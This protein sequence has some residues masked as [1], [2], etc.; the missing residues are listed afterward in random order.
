MA[1]SQIAY[2]GGDVVVTINAI[3][4]TGTH[5]AVTGL[6]AS[7]LSINGTASAVVPTVAN[8]DTGIY[9]LTWT[10][11]T[12]T[13]EGDS[14]VALIDGSISGTAFSTYGIPVKVVAFERGTNN[15]STFDNTTDQVTVSTNNDKTGYSLTTAP[16]TA[17]QIYAEFTSGTNEDAFKADVT[18]IAA[19]VAALNDLSAADV[20]TAIGL[21]SAN[22]DT[23]LGDIPTV[24]ELNAR[25]KAT[26]DYFDP[27]T[28]AVANVTTVGTVTNAVTAGTVNDKTGYSI[29]GTKQTLDQLNDIAATAIVSGGA[30]TTSGGAVSNVTTVATTTTNT[31]MRGT[32]SAFLAADAPANFS[33]LGINANGHVSQ[34]T[35]VDTTTANTDMRGTDGANTVAPDNTS[36]TAIKAKTDQLAFTVANQVDANSLTGGITASQVTDAV[37]DATI[38]SH[39][40]AG[41]FGRG[42][43]QVKE[44]LI[45]VDGQVNDTSATATSFVTNL[46]S[47][48][49]DFYND[50]TIHFISGS[51]QGQSRVVVDY[52]GT[53]K[54]ITLDQ[55]LT[56]APANTDEFIVLSNHVHSVGEIVTS[57]WSEPQTSYTTAGT[58]GYFLDDQV[59]AVSGG[60]GGTGTTAAQIYSYFT[61]GTNADVFKADVT[62]IEGVTDKLDTM[63][64]LDSGSTT[65]YQFDA[66]ALELA[67]TGSGGSG[68]SGPTAAE[69]YAEFIS[70]TNADAFKADVSALATQSSVDT[71]G[72]DVDAILVDTDTTIPNAIA[73]V[74]TTANTIDT[75]T[76]SILQ[77]TNTTIPASIAGV[78]T[79]ANTIDTTTASILQDTDTTI[80]ASIDAIDTKIDTIDG[81][82][83]AILVDTSTDI[84]NAIAGISGGGGGGSGPTAAQIYA[85]FTTGT[86]AD[87]FKADVTGLATQASVNAIDANVDSIL[88]DTSTTI[89]GSISS[90]DAKVDTVDGNV[91][92]I[93]AKTDQLQFSVANQV[94]ANAL[95]GGTPVGSGAVSHQITVNADGVPQDGVEVWASTDEQGTNVSAG[96]L[97]TDAFGNATFLLDAGTYYLWAQKSGYNF[98]NPTQ[99]TV[100]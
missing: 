15:A 93:K 43:R 40:N 3:D 9:V 76:A 33:S 87:P 75:T 88:E 90:L 86:N 99:F 21:A 85:E 10:P 49:D 7:R 44:G 73:G 17:A 2:A 82:V 62:A 25:T 37:W 53:T 19:A 35:L 94:D 100:S 57:V 78:Q 28:D 74:Q 6:N 51:L 65:D 98:P 12:A 83:D 20:R 54:S 56:S 52:N 42:F 67:P 26:A 61:S 39:N 29:S 58:F 91:D 50:Q 92:S 97:V 48:V 55:A 70:G 63:I 38:A 81:V 5:V 13:S 4:S 30:I 95:T 32:D 71:I 46:S 77:D 79:T 23:Q 22:L 64:A 45:S 24:A 60:S 68:G 34:V 80:P 89:P 31:D 72:T 69:I 59:S 47:S 84:P 1:S 16:P 36:I 27:A 18:G 8:P 96:V 14:I 66:V 11:S 41:S